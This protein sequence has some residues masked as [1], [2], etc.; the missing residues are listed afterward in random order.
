MSRKTSVKS[1]EKL[2]LFELRRLEIG[3]VSIDDFSLLHAS[4]STEAGALRH[5]SVTTVL[6]FFAYFFASN[7]PKCNLG[8]DSFFKTCCV[9]NF[10]PISSSKLLCIWDFQSIGSSKHH[11]VWAL[12]LINSLKDNL[13]RCSNQSILRKIMY[14][15]ERINLI[16]QFILYCQL[17]L[18]RIS[19]THLC[20]E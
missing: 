10:Q 3:G 16:C 2:S 15:Q 9:W 7:P 20:C 5:H 17:S 8:I 4:F 6:T 12:Q 11:C 19:K 1:G 18:C 13:L 14:S